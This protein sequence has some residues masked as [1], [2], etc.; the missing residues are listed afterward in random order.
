MKR[1]IYLIAVVII[2]NYVISQEMTSGT[3]FFSVG[4][5]P[6]VNYWNIYHSGG[7]PA[8]KITLDRGYKQAGPGIITL[9]GSLGFFSKYYKSTYYD[10]GYAYSYKSTWTFVSTVFRMGYYYNLK[11]ADIPDMNVYGGLGLG[12]LYE[13]YKYSY[14]GPNHPN[15]IRDNAGMHFLMN[16]YLGANYFLSPKTAIYLEFGYDI[17]YATV[18]LTFKL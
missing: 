16:L 3:N 14:T 7:T 11:E 4:I 17:T 12:L 2:S 18:G 15:F 13:G 9:G 8:L 6:S 10:N 5:G 1:I